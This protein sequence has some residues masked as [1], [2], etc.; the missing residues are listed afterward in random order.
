MVGRASGPSS[1]MLGMGLPAME[2]VAARPPGTGLGRA[3]ARGQT[4]SSTWLVV[5]SVC[6]DAGGDSSKTERAAHQAPTTSEREA[7]AHLVLIMCG[8]RCQIFVQPVW[9]QVCKM[10]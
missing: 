4:R 3:L 2:T 5:A 1:A 8:V 10:L 7:C 9:C 6:A